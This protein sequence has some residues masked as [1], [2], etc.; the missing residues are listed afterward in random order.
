MSAIAMINGRLCDSLPLGDRGF[1]YGDGLFETIR[2]VDGQGLLWDY[3]LRR[4]VRGCE[5]LKIPVPGN[6]EANLQAWLKQ[7][8][9]AVLAHAS[10]FNAD[11]F[12]LKIVLTRGV[13]GRGYRPLDTS[14]NPA[15]YLSLHA[16]P[17]DLG[18]KQR[19]GLSAKLLNY[20]LVSHPVLAGLKHLNRLDQVLASLELGH[21]DEGLLLNQEGHLIEGTKSNLLLYV[22]G[23]FVTP[24]LHDCGVEGVLREWLIAPDNPVGIPVEVASVTADVLHDATGLAVINSVM[25]VCPVSR[26]NGLEWGVPDQ[27]RH[28]QQVV[29]TQ[30]RF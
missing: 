14:S 8:L 9:T 1:A 27:L 11:D 13:G 18:E 6:L 23:G 29:H 16:V 19:T 30:L 10:G 24:A 15:I 7:L 28:L 17:A 25:G 21:E 2:V 4:L 22:N 12:V 26:F 20:R 5:R 3:H